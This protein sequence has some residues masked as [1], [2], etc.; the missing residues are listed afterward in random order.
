MKQKNV[1]KKFHEADF[2]GAMDGA[3]KFVKGDA[4]A[5]IQLA[6]NIIGL[7]IGVTQHDLDIGQASE[8]YI[9]LSVEMDLLHKYHHYCRN[10]YR[11]HSYPCLFNREYGSSHR[12]TN[13][14]QG[15]D[16]VSAVLLNG[17]VPAC[18][19]HYSCSRPPLLVSW[20]V[21]RQR[22]NKRT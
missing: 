4:V 21:M 22:K 13:F 12:R 5:G 1:A 14:Y 3:S 20:F 8:T 11:N 18:L 6:I 9:L 17:L 15:L 10:R 7:I 2:Y 16:S 19:T